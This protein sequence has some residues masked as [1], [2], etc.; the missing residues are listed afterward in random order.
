MLPEQW[1]GFWGTSKLW[2]LPTELSNHCP[3]VLRYEDADWG[4][5]PFRFQNCWLEHRGL[6]EVVKKELVRT[7]AYSMEGV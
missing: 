2:A 4:H 3:F 1:L 6:A 5:P 7:L